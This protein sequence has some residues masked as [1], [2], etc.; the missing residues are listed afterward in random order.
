VQ[1]SPWRIFGAICL[2]AVGAAILVMIAQQNDAG[3][4]DFIAYCK[5]AMGRTPTIAERFCAWSVPQD[6]TRIVR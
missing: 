1:R 5:C 2:L 3:R 6:S 4:R